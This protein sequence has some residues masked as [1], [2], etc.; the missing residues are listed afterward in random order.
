MLTVGKLD[1]F[2]LC[3]HRLIRYCRHHFFLEI[4]KPTWSRTNSLPA[5]FLSLFFDC[6][7]F[8]WEEERENI[9]VFFE[10]N[11]NCSNFIFLKLVLRTCVQLFRPIRP[12]V[13]EKNSFEPQFR[14]SLE[15]VSCS[16]HQR[17]HGSPACFCSKSQLR[18]FFSM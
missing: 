13:F 15:V 12:T 10:K 17:I 18:R 5:V 7:T 3:S 2:E 16:F 1:F 8:Y 11:D 4:G 9:F 14:H 6:L